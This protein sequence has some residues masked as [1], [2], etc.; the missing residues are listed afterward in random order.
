MCHE[1]RTRFSTSASLSSISF[2]WA[3][4]LR[5]AWPQVELVVG[6]VCESL[7]RHFCVVRLL[8]RTRWWRCRGASNKLSAWRNSPDMAEPCVWIGKEVTASVRQRGCL[9]ERVTLGECVGIILSRCGPAW[10]LSL[11]VQVSRICCPYRPC[12][13]CQVSW[14]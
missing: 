2:A 6:G 14:L 12:T 3:C 10:P 4:C 9:I 5:G 11:W 8:V 7:C 13:P 1:F